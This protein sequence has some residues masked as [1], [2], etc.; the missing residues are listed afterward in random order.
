MTFLEFLLTAAVYLIF[1]GITRGYAEHR[2]PKR[3]RYSYESRTDTDANGT[4]KFFTTVFWPFYW[5]FIW[6]FTKANEVTFSLIEK[7]TAHKIKTNKIRV[8]EFKAS[9]AQLE[10]SNK[11]LETA[12]L[13]LEKE[14]AKGL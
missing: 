8:E 11:E 6:P 12:E 1:C 4:K 2:W 7:K 10:E 9:K 5:V 3:M 13:E 14:I